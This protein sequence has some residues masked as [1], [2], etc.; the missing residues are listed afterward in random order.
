M[1]VF[2]SEWLCAFWLASLLN[3]VRAT[4][5]QTLSVTPVLGNDLGLGFLVTLVF[6]LLGTVKT[7]VTVGTHSLA[8]RSSP[9]LLCHREVDVGASYLMFNNSSSQYIYFR[10]RILRSK[11][12]V[13]DTMLCLL[14][15]SNL[16][17]ES[18]ASFVWPPN[19]AG[20][21][22]HG[23]VDIHTPICVL[24]SALCSVFLRVSVCQF[25]E[26]DSGFWCYVSKK[27][28][29]K[30]E[31]HMLC[32]P[33]FVCMQLFLCGWSKLTNLNWICLSNTSL[34]G[35]IFFSWLVFRV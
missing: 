28:C 20:Q 2:R 19:C 6:C 11:S 12:S 13:F 14:L 3:V 21:I 29:F 4:S 22:A 33:L 24:L 23:H 27:N 35:C 7:C 9:T 5:R 30:C 18:S 15:F 1:S 17:R 32:L 25:L 16:T 34:N 31:W 26:N 10:L 8:L